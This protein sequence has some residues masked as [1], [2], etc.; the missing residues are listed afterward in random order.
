MKNNESMKD[1]ESNRTIFKDFK[2]MEIVERVE[3]YRKVRGDRIMWT[4][5][6]KQLKVRGNSWVDADLGVAMGTRLICIYPEMVRR[7]NL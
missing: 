6:P 1:R 5:V 2:L 4:Y 3:R 7:A